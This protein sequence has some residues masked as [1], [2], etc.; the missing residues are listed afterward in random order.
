ML[1]LHA[2]ILCSL[3]NWLW[4]LRVFVFFARCTFFGLE[5]TCW[6]A[7]RGGCEYRSLADLMGVMEMIMLYIFLRAGQKTVAGK[8]ILCCMNVP[9]NPDVTCLNVYTYLDYSAFPSG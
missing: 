8:R 9:P 6:F 3:C 5:G 7:G 1:L 2:Y 4:C